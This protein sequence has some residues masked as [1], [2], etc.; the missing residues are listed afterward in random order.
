MI[1]RLAMPE[2]LV[3]ADLDPMPWEVQAGAAERGRAF[4]DLVA[5]RMAVP[6]GDDETSR[7]IRAHEMMH[8]KV[9]P[10]RV[11]APDEYAYL[12]DELLTVAEEFRVNMLCDAAGFP[13]RQHLHDGSERLTGARLAGNGDWNTL[14]QMTAATSGTKAFSGLLAGVKSTRAD[15]VPT[16]R[17][18]DRQLRRLWRARTKNGTDWVASTER[19]GP[20]SHHLPIG[21]QFTIEVAQLLTRALI[22]TSSDGEVPPDPDALKPSGA[23]NVPRFGKLVELETV[24][25]NRVDGRLGRRKRPTNIGRH[26]RHLDRLLVDPERRVFDRK[27]RGK[28]GVVLID[29][30]GSMRLADTDLW[31]IIDA[32]PGCVIIG[33]SHAAGT[34]GKPN[35]WVLADRGRV[36]DSVPPGNSGNGVDG[37]AISFALRRRKPGE[38]MVW[39]CD[40]YVTDGDDDE[41]HP[42]LTDECARLV[43][44]NGIHMVPT[45][46]GAVAA[47]TRAAHGERLTARAVGPIATATAWRSRT[48]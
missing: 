44:T 20:P 1:E 10:I 27:L 37:P 5:R 36:V 21:W 2:W 6:F 32:A 48:P 13:V 47:L 43:A 4:T 7:C 17:E 14:V 38:P 31:R 22:T 11:S 18:L 28:G 39:V 26:P 15:W 35:I 19:W 40:G 46:D 34:E 16:I 41:R 42:E 29:Q 12:G 8:A 9:S 33:Y 23:R 3:R 25:P 24:K 45:V 30:S